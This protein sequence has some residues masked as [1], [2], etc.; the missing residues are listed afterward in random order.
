MKQISEFNSF[1]ELSEEMHGP[2]NAWY[3]IKIRMAELEALCQLMFDPENQPPQLSIEDA[4]RRFK[5]GLE[6]G[7]KGGSGEVFQGDSLIHP[8]VKVENDTGPKSVKK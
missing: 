2:A 1:R 6:P 8:A 5:T 7:G 3:L 4:W